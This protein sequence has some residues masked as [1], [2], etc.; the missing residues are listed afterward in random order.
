MR[1]VTILCLVLLASALAFGQ[2]TIVGGTATSGPATVGL[3]AAPFVPRIST[4]VVSLSTVS[5]NPVGATSATYG[6]VAGA[7]NSTLSIVTPPPTGVFTQPLLY[8]PTAPDPLMYFQTVT[9]APAGNTITARSTGS[10]MA[11]FEGNVSA[12][13]L[14]KSYGPAKKAS[15]TITNADVDR[16]NQLTGTVKYDGKTEQ[17]K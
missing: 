11:S 14:M 17:M 2:A 13:E 15:R 4:P 1:L 16:F 9:S 6:N 3:Y 8:N 5:P 7:T 12:A 10:G